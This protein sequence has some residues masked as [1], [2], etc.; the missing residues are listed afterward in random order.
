MAEKNVYKELAK[1]ILYDAK[2]TAK[3]NI[4]KTYCVFRCMHGALMVESDSGFESIALG[5]IEGD[6][7][8]MYI[9]YAN[10][11]RRNSYPCMTRLAGLLESIAKKEK[12]EE[13]EGKASYHCDDLDYLSKLVT[14]FATL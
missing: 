5:D 2:I 14:A 11:S 8:Y 7:G 6:K 1:K 10:T 13:G 12:L 3:D 4:E 9:Y